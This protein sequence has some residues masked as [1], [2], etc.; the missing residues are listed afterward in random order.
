LALANNRMAAVLK[1]GY[2][3]RYVFAVDAGHTDVP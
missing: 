3:Y 1:K 2:D